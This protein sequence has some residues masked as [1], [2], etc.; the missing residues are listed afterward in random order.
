M[1]IKDRWKKVLVIPCKNEGLDFVNFLKEIIHKNADL[2][3]VVVINANSQDRSECQKA[4]ECL[5]QTIKSLWTFEGLTQSESL[6]KNI[7]LIERGSGDFLFPSK[8]G[9][10]LARRIG[11]DI[12]LF[13]IT[14]RQIELPWIWTTDTDAK[15]PNDYFQ[16]L[17][18]ISSEFSA[19]TYP[20][21]HLQGE[22]NASN[23]RALKEYENFLHYYVKGLRFSGSPYAYHSI[24]SCLA[25]RA[26][27]YA[28]VRGFPL[29]QA[30]EDFYV[31]NKLAKV[32]KILKVNSSP[33]QLSGRLSDR[34]PFGTGP[35]T[36]E[37]SNNHLQGK[38]YLVYNPRCFQ[39]LRDLLIFFE[40]WSNMPEAKPHPHLPPKLFDY[41]LKVGGFEQL[42]SL[43]TR[44]RRASD[45]LRRLHEWFDAFQSLKL[46]HYFSANH[47]AKIP[48]KDALEDLEKAARFSG[49]ETR[50]SQS[51]I[52]VYTESG[53]PQIC[54]ES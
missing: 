45:R 4:N 40:T 7:L 25:I 31:L 2:L 3:I 42:A 46:V 14:N 23:Y 43:E 18:G 9:V 28:K 39:I 5:A 35:S 21:V 29:K 11:S 41:F 34:T 33:I 52:G 19:A 38:S 49:H 32:G 6:S 8:Q 30:G 1:N 16:C 27:A 53:Q 17:E 22:L 36:I 12:A 10:G 24:G 50:R 15:L 51:R 26:E 54:G 20:F 47:Y 13:L 44:A 37:I 48:L